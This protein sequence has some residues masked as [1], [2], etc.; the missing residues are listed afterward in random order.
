MPTTTL[1]YTPSPMWYVSP[2]GVRTQKIFG[3]PY[4]YVSAT[5]PI[6]VKRIRPKGVELLFNQTSWECRRIKYISSWATPPLA[7]TCLLQTNPSIYRTAN[8]VPSYFKETHGVSYPNPNLMPDFRKLES[9][10][11]S[12]IK[13]ESLNLY[14]QMLTYRQTATVFTSGVKEL[15]GI[16]RDVKRGRF[17]RAFKKTSKFY[18]YNRYAL[19]PF[20][21][22]LDTSATL[23]ETELR[24][25][26]FKRFVAAQSETKKSSFYQN[27]ALFDDVQ[28]MSC[29]WNVICE[30]SNELMQAASRTGLTSP[31]FALWDVVPFSFVVDWFVDVGSFLDNMDALFAVKRHASYITLK[32]VASRKGYGVS[33]M[34]WNSRQE[35]LAREPR[36]LSFLP[37]LRVVTGVNL[38]HS[39][40]LLNLI[41]VNLK[42]R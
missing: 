18:L 12:K 10:V 16:L 15:W 21:M 28:E 6:A 4:R 2:C 37:P 3:N 33:T 40:D 35:I 25:G 7:M 8:V 23:L 27:G 31:A 19:N 11:L 41:N 22:D 5:R 36:S 39:L 38:Q 34:T 42:G 26:V 9:K 13:G 30:F 1:A 29:R 20:M 14:M 24:N 32:R 17:E